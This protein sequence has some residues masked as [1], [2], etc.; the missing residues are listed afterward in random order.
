M[1]VLVA[2]S[3]KYETWI[4]S[5]T[6]T[7]SDNGAGACGVDSGRAEKIL[8]Y[9]DYCAAFAGTAESISAWQVEPPDEPPARIT[10][11]WLRERWSADVKHLL[12]RDEA[13]FA[14]RCGALAEYTD[15]G[16]D[17]VRH[18]RRGVRYTTNGSGWLVA[19]AA[20]DS[21][22]EYGERRARVLCTAG[23]RAACRLLPSEC[24][25]PMRCIRVRATA[26]AM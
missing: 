15:R 24:R 5:D 11:R 19:R 2:V 25:L 20:V 3:D 21:L 8:R 17:L 14:F 1:T 4:A 12:N 18:H 7:T 10:E 6:A 9:P 16:I 26:Y 13:I 23:V 22:I